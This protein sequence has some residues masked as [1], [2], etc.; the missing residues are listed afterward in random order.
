MKSEQYF[1]PETEQKS[2]TDKFYKAYSYVGQYAFTAWNTRRSKFQDVAVRTALARAFDERAWIKVK[3][4][5]LA[6]P[7][8]GPTF[9]LSPFYNQDVHLLDYE[10]EKAT[11]ELAE[12]GWYDRNGD[13]TIDKDGEEFVFEFLY[14]SGNRASQDMGQKLQESYAKIGVKVNLQP[15]EWATFKERALARDFDALNMAWTLPEPE[16]DPRQIWASSEANKERTSNYSS[17]SDPES[18]RLI[19][20]IES[21][22]DA[23]AARAAV[24]RPARAHLRGAA[25]PVRPDPAAEVR[26]QQAAARREALQLPAR[27]PRARHVVRRGHARDPAAAEVSP[28]APAAC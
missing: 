16:S 13:G 15:L 26:L 18:D 2:F 8:T 4:K 10:P 24:A 27:L 25:V 22:P 19:D 23:T 20:A 5:D 3:Y 12:A 7:V 11:E 9:F 1:G 28:D 6:V 17:Y 21:E 14:P